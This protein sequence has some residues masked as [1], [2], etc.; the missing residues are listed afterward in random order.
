MNDSMVV[1]V[2]FSDPE[3]MGYPFD[4]ADYFNAY[5]RLSVLCAENKIELYFAR[6]EASYLGE[7]CFQNGYR[8]QEGELVAIGGPFDC[9]LIYLKGDGERL[10]TGPDDFV[11]NNPELD[12][13]GH[14][15]ELT[16]KVL[17]QFMAPTYS[18]S[19]AN[20]EE[21]KN[22]IK[23]DKIVL[24]PSLGLGGKGILVL[25]KNELQ[26]ELIPEDEPYLAQDFIDSSGGIPGLV[27]GMH[28]MRLIMFNGEAT[29]SFIR[30]PK[31]GSFLS[32]V[33]QGGT[34]MIASIDKVPASA[35]AIAQEV[36]RRFAR[37][38]PRIYTIDFMYEGEKPY[39][40]EINTRPGLAVA[41]TE[42]EEFTQQ[43][44]GRLIALFK[45][46]AIQHK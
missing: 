27:E 13:I 42:G 9:D 35:L 18:I 6:G 36:D 1:C 37:F 3:K 28:D 15:K 38:Y 12:D 39:I 34:L 31:P 23:T 19:R 26:P 17:G 14:D 43:F 21:V 8:F 5:K 11:I 24:K 46:S 7:M 30:T 2:Y 22:K 25:P 16:Y 4:D 40:C 10:V 20:W 41:E 44:Y 33:A 29:F 45:D 32:N